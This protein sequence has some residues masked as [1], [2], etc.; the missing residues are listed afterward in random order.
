MSGVFSSSLKMKD[1]VSHFPQ[2]HGVTK[3]A[4]EAFVVSVEPAPPTHRSPQRTR[5]KKVYLS[6]ILVTAVWWGVQEMSAFVS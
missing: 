3:P 5:K 4:S 2:S 1:I 6:C